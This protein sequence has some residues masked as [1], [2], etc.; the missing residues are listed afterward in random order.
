MY[1]SDHREEARSKDL[2]EN[3]DKKLKFDKMRHDSDSGQ[4]A[5]PDKGKEGHT[6]K[7]KNIND[8]LEKIGVKS[9]TNLTYKEQQ[10]ERLPQAVN[11]MVES[12]KAAMQHTPSIQT[13]S[14][15]QNKAE[16]V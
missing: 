16:K 14:T 12:S 10:A 4:F 1:Q 6:N 2:D 7:M 3:I 9:N 5:I 11:R 8:I 15:P 13:T